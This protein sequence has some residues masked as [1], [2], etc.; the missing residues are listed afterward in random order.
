MTKLKN[1]NNEEEKTRKKTGNKTQKY[2][3]WKQEK[4]L[5]NKFK[6]ETVTKPNNSDYDKTEKL[7]LRRKKERENMRQN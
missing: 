1:S 7:K 2:E 6:T 4:K 5:W 3:L